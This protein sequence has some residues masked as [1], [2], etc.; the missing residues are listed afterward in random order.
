MGGG[1]VERLG[2]G[3]GGFWQRKGSTL[4]SATAAP[5]MSCHVTGAACSLGR[6]LHGITPALQTAASLALTCLWPGLLNHTSSS[7]TTCTKQ[8]FAIL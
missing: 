8:P 1:G 7:E 2:G 5:L 6:T 3:E 4:G